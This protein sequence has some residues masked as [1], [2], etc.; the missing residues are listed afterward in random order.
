MSDSG[1]STAPWRRVEAMSASTLFARVLGCIAVLSLL[2]SCSD[3]A[4]QGT[5]DLVVDDSARVGPCTVYRVGRYRV[6]GRDLV[7]LC[8]QTVRPTMS[9]DR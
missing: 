1:G 3:I 5:S 9:V 4:A 6:G 8:P 2:A 7:V